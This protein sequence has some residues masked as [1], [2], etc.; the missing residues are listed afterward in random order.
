VFEVFSKIYL[1]DLA[2][3]FPMTR[4]MPLGLQ[5][6]TI[7]KIFNKLN[8]DAEPDNLD[9]DNLDTVCCFSE[10]YHNMANAHPD[11]V[12][13]EETLEEIEQKI[14]DNEIQKLIDSGLD[15]ET[16]DRIREE[17]EMQ[18]LKGGWKKGWVAGRETFTKTVKIKSH[19]KGKYM[20]GIIRTTCE[21]EFIGLEAKVTFVKP[22][23]P[24]EK[25]SDWELAEYE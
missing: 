5:K 3:K 22:E 4:R 20:R 15:E 19:L 16:I 25:P 17:M 12:W 21:P 8:P 1:H 13:F 7:L 9:W 11:Y 10:N 6:Y 24:K 23:K 14:K 2:Q 18:S